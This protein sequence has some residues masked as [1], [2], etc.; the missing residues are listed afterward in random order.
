MKKCKI[1][2]LFI[3]FYIITVFQGIFNLY[4]IPNKYEFLSSNL[5]ND[6][7]IFIILMYLIF[8]IFICSLVILFDLIIYLISVN[9]FEDNRFSIRFFLYPI[10]IGNI[11]NL[12][13]NIFIQQFLNINVEIVLYNLKYISMVGLAFKVM[14]IYV[15]FKNKQL[16][17]RNIRL[18]SVGY[19]IF[20][21][22][23]SLLSFL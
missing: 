16:N 4:K 10:L 20:I 15:Y 7:I 14:Y 2:F 5:I 17:V 6:N 21:Y 22:L 8:Q 23:V 1:I 13:I 9:K 3:L 12:I 11:I 19:F 18:I